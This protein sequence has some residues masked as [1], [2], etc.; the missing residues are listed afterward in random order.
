MYIIRV[1][2]Q[3]CRILEELPHENAIFKDYNNTVQSDIISDERKSVLCGHEEENVQNEELVPVKIK[4]RPP[5]PGSKIANLANII[6]YKL[7][8]RPELKP[9]GGVDPF[10]ITDITDE[11]VGNN[12]KNS[13]QEAREIIIKSNENLMD[14][15]LHGPGLIVNSRWPDFAATL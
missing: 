7:Y 2:R 3:E 14:M 13:E 5:K 8:R 11:D 10:D 15:T 6:E 1:V 12:E 9:S 4:L